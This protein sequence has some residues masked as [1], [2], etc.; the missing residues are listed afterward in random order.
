MYKDAVEYKQP[1]QVLARDLFAWR[2]G[3]L[4]LDDP[5][6]DRIAA[7]ELHGEFATLNF[8]KNN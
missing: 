7:I 3:R 6:Q 4:H 2:L 1:H 5:G 8:S